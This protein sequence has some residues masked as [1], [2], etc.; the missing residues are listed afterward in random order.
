M[1]IHFKEISKSLFLVN[2]FLCSLLL[3][4]CSKE[5]V[6]K[7]GDW[8]A[9]QVTV[10]G[11]YCKKNMFNVSPEGGVYKLYSK[12]YG[13]LWLNAVAENR[14]PVWYR[15][16][17]PFKDI[18]LEK[19]WYEVQYDEKDNIVVTIQSI[20]QEASSRSLTFEIECGDAFGSFTLS[21]S[22]E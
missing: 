14:V 3:G 10:N 18:H 5:K 19:E 1:K 6:L 20:E 16:E 2:L 13:M 7:D 11:D 8:P 15:E 4:G 12:N 9:I 22:P 17:I 21:Q